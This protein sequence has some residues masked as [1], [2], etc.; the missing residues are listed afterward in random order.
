[1]GNKKRIYIIH[2]DGLLYYE[3]LKTLCESGYADIETYHLHFFKNLAKGIIRRKPALVLKA[4]QSIVFF[5]RSFFI[6]GSVFLIGMAPYDPAVFLWSRLLKN[7]KVIYHTSWPYWEGGDT[8]VKPLFAEAAVKNKW[9]EFITHPNLS[10]VCVL[11]T[12]RRALIKNFGKAEDMIRV[13][14]HCVDTVSFK[15]AKR[16]SLGPL[17]VL[18]TGRLMREKGLEDLC[19]VI[20]KSGGDFEFG[21]AGEGRDKSL[22]DSVINLPN[23]R[24]YGRV[25]G[26]REMA[27]VMRDYDVM[28]LM[29]YKRPGWE[30]LFGMV[31]IEAFASGL[32]VV[33]TDCI[34]PVNII[35]NRKNGFIIKQRNVGSAVKTLRAL[36]ANRPLLRKLGTE[37]V[38]SAKEYTIEKIMHKW[39]AAI[40]A[41]RG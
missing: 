11:D 41:A 1:M 7:N 26:R 34:G 24:Y 18:F 14:P 39:R 20:R 28:L 17:K 29:S 10:V 12:T 2:D 30:E 3:A 31:I 16:K 8:P 13:I 36:S 37:A 5:I 6:K 22:L 21:I 35:K 23:V 15:P 9:R 32:A 19:E 25:E 27:N 4:M 40:K 33:S 38:K